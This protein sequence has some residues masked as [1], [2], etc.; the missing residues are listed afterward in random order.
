M[1]SLILLLSLLIIGKF[2]SAQQSYILSG[3]VKDK[4]G[5][6]LPGAGV[7]VSGYKIATA[8][9]NDGTYT[10]PLKPGNYDILVQLIGYKALNKNIVISDKAIKLDLV[11]E[12]SITQLNEVTIKPDPNRA[13]YIAM[14]KDFFIGT[15]PN[16]AQCKMI[17]PNVLLI[18]YDNEEAKL[19]VKTNQFLIIENQALGYRIKYLVNNFEYS[20]RSKIMYYEGYP[21]YEDLKGSSRKKKIWEKKRLTAYLG[22]PQHFFKSIY[23]GKATE[24]GFIINKLITRPNPDKPSDSTIKVNIKRLTKVQ[25]G[26]LRRTIT[27]KNDDSLNY[28]IRKKNLPDGIS[29]LS[30]S[31]IAQD[32][33]VHF[34]NQS[35]KSINFT[36]KLYIVYTKE[37]EDP[38]FANRIGLSISRPL[39]MPD[40]QISTIT[41]QVKPVY[42]YENGGIYNPRSM[43]YTGYWAW[44]KIADSVPMDYLPPVNREKKK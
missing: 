42:F 30:R 9:N 26:L 20:S 13:Y 24:E 7:Y 15:T 16:A 32:T 33:L 14:F 22:S 8:S 6:A 29:I 43:L 23:N 25:D 12:E 4:H 37:K 2:C 31:P 21:Y 18:D 28:W 40:Y 3:I 17:N 34:K 19:K 44:E 36:D 39:D 35:I 27:I 11:L 5:E 1:K 38:L 41:L 10:L